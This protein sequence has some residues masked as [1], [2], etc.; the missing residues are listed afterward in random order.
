M[1]RT[2]SLEPSSTE[3]CMNP[4][5]LAEEDL[6]PIAYTDHDEK[7]DTTHNIDPSLKLNGYKFIRKICDTQ[8]GELLEAT[9]HKSSAVVIKK[10]GNALF[11]QQ[12]TKKDAF[13]MTYCIPNNILKEAIILNH[14]TVNNHCQCNYMVEFVHLFYSDQHFYL[15]TKQIDDDTLNLKQF[16]EQAQKH[17]R[18]GKL[19]I[20]GYLKVIKFIFWQLSVWLHWMHNDMHCCHLDLTLEHVLLK[21]AGFIIDPKTETVTA[22]RSTS[23]RVCDFGS[24]ELFQNGVFECDKP[25]SVLRPLQYQSPGFKVVCLSLQTMPVTTRSGATSDKKQAN[26][27]KEP[28][29]GNCNSPQTMDYYHTAPTQVLGPQ[30]RSQRKR[31]QNQ[32]S[33]AS[34]GGSESNQTD[35]YQ[36]P[37]NKK[38]KVQYQHIDT[39]IPQRRSTRIA[40]KQSLNKN[41]FSNLENMA[42]EMDNEEKDISQTNSL[43]R[44]RSLRLSNGHAIHPPHIDAM[45]NTNNHWRNRLRRSVRTDNKPKLEADEE[46]NANKRK[47]DSDYGDA[48]FEQD[49]QEEEVVANETEDDMIDADDDPNGS[50][51]RRSQRLRGKGTI[52]YYNDGVDIRV[53]DENPKEDEVEKSNSLPLSLRRPKRNRKPV[54]NIYEVEQ[55]KAYKIKQDRRQSLRSKKPVNYAESPGSNEEEDSDSDAMATISPSRSRSYSAA[56][57]RRNQRRNRNRN[58]SR[59]RNRIRR[60]RRSYSSDSSSSYSTDT[61]MEI[62]EQKRIRK[63]RRK[64][65]PIQL[66]DLGL[67]DDAMAPNLNHNKRQKHN[68]TDPA[69]ITP[70]EID[71][72]IGWDMVGG[73]E[74]HV[75]KLKEMVIL[76]LL[77]PSEFAEFKMSTPR[78]VLFHGPPG[79]GKTLVARILA[80]QCSMGHKAKKVAFYMRKG[81]D[82]LSKWVGEAER[83]LRL[84]FDE[85]HKNQPAVIFFDE[86]DGLAPVRS[87]RQ[88]QIHSS[89]VSTLLALMDG[90][91]SRGQIIVIGATNRPDAIDPALRRPGRFDREL[92]FNLPTKKARKEILK[93][94]TKSWNETTCQLDEAM[95][96]YLSEQSVGYCGA[97][98][99]ALCRE[100]FLAA[101]RR[102]YPQI[103]HSN[104]RLQIDTKKL[105]IKQEDFEVAL[106]N[107]TPSSQRSSLVF[108]RTIP[109]LL[110]PLLGRQ[111]QT[112]KR[113]IASVFSLKKGEGYH[114]H[115]RYLIYGKDHHQGQ[116]YL[117]RAV[118]HLLEE[119][120]MYSLD[121]ASLYGDSTTKCADESILRIFK[122]AQRNTPSVIYWPHIHRWWETAHDIL[123]TSISLLIN[124]ISKDCPILI[125]ATCNVLMEDMDQDL[126]QLFDKFSFHSTDQATDESERNRFW[127]QIAQFIKEKPK[128]KARNIEQYPT[129]PIAELSREGKNDKNK[130]GKDTGNAES[131]NQTESE[132]LIEQQKMDCV[133]LRVYIRS[134]CNRLC[135]HFKNFI[136]QMAEDGV[137]RNNLSLFEIRQRNNERD[138]PTVIAFLKDIDAL[139][140][141]V[142]DSAQTDSLKARQFINEACHLQ[143]QALSMMSQVNRDLV[144]HCDRMATQHNESSA[145]KKKVSFAAHP[146]LLLGDKS[147]KEDEDHEEEDVEIVD[148]TNNKNNNHNTNHKEMEEEEEEE[149]EIEV[150]ESRVSAMIDDLVQISQHYVVEEMEE[151]MNNLLRIIYR[152][153]NEWNKTKL[154]DE[155]NDHIQTYFKQKHLISL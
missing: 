47:L 141:N 119:Y 124:D 143:D 26:Y 99:E 41:G 11:R 62:R 107:I 67:Y 155:L 61:L 95:F 54:I 2:P 25:C 149:R 127:N 134:V 122:E 117:G 32:I 8:Q 64:I 132:A 106:K 98:L 34:D 45:D 56:K 84:L 150:N 66:H 89:I 17:I 118:L 72:N 96:N 110:Q 42:E 7:H 38:R 80:A 145:R 123:K 23:I 133:N 136:D 15:V 16:I 43:P 31:K 139:V 104:V 120:P 154:L 50:A 101:V 86:I 12:I 100:S 74:G 111:L 109:E 55:Y 91:D 112:I 21:D 116:N 20:K 39:P 147:E 146:V 144:K 5:V 46:D 131:N 73:L 129:L 36:P 81:A 63:E 108:A 97:D 90:L 51:R 153:S 137:V 130:N 19:N 142:K 52:H 83:Q 103:Y 59:N 78:G 126:V 114:A 10:V 53:E 88:D 152:Y 33:A 140:Q 102:T 138:I 76:P 77:Y 30:T 14:L 121:L 128:H 27:S 6:A 113:D 69:D 93:I 87:S 68:K 105:E 75:Q 79:T 9:D 3:C 58:R 4:G 82:C 135:K 13:G 29:N 57:R 115:Y 35:E 44:R 48:E 18:E 22:K 24:A 70:M 85:A 92:C 94:H 71:M 60:R 40:C 28:F 37:P 65:K 1:S 151:R 49:L 148:H 125:V